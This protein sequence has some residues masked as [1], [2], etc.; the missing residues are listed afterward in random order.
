MKIGVAALIC[1]LMLTACGD[2]SGKSKAHEAFK[3]KMDVALVIDGS[4][5]K[6]T[7]DTDMHISPEHYGLRRQEGEGH[8]HMYLDDLPK[9]GVKERVY[10]FPDLTSGHHKL[11]ISLHNNDHTPYDVTITKEFDIQ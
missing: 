1:C 4:K 11:K 9:V 10:V 8:I 5:I 3:P 2:N 7:V 6:V